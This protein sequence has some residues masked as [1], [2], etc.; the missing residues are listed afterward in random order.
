[1]SGCSGPA[2]QAGP[3]TADPVLT[4]PAASAQTDVGA[5]AEGTATAGASGSGSVSRSLSA[6]ELARIRAQLD[7]M[8]KEIDT[9]EMPT[10]DDFNSAATDL[11]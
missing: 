8:Q 9:L 6:K 7:A 10:D 1:M 3:V 2:S 11:Y 5:G 4:S